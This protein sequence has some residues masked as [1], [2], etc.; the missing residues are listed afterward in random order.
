MKKNGRR[1]RRQIKRLIFERF[2]DTGKQFWHQ[3]LSENDIR[4]IRIYTD[5][6]KG[7]FA[8]LPEA[9]TNRQTSPLKEHYV[10]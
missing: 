1:I 4:T 6:S 2:Q 7:I 10:S 8:G 5:G 3:H 9:L